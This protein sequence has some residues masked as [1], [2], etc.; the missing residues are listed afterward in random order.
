MI[1][2]I[3][4]LLLKLKDAEKKKIDEL[5]ITHPTTIGNMYEG[6]TEELLGRAVFKDLG[7]SI[8]TNS[9]IIDN[10]GIRSDEMDIVLFQGE[11]SKILYTDQYDVHY[12][13]V[14]AVIQ[15]KKR[16]NKAHLQS[17]Y[18][19]LRNVYEIHEID[20]V[21]PYHNRMFRNAYVSICN[22]DVIEN[23]KLRTNFRSGTR[24]Q[25]FHILKVEAYTPI[26]IVF[27]YE[28]YSSEYGLRKGFLKMLSENKST[29]EDMKHGFGP[30]QFPNLVVN[31]KYSLIKNNGMPYIA[32]MV[33]EQWLFYASSSKNP[34][35]HLLE[36]VWTRLS[37]MFEIS[38]DIFGEDLELEGMN[39]FLSGN[40]VFVDG[41]LGWN[42][43]Y[44][45]LSKDKLEEIEQLDE[46]QDWEPLKISEEI[47]YIIAYLAKNEKL[48]VTKV[49]TV[50]SIIGK[51][52]DMDSFIDQLIETRLVGINGRKFLVLLTDECKCM[53]APDG[54]YAA[55]DKSGRFTRWAK[56]KFGDRIID[57]SSNG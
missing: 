15:V 1:N 50:L 23:K 37:Y 7:L 42:Y 19:N 36:L 22:E 17:A 35:Y 11:A 16:L 44:T 52:V 13:Q 56:K 31:G 46:I 4:D 9:F 51:Q 2:T 30:I 10:N 55:E 32:P 12:A 21:E 29:K 54:Y 25:M 14:I 5:G 27:G 48:L 26:R 49:N 41:M 33:D 45:N 24:E 43:M 20:K 34:I 8:V 38:S 3:A 39:L 18:N 47:H 40:T 57:L 28:G 6:L 53:V